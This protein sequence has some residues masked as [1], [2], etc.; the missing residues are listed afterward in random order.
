MFCRDSGATFSIGID[1]HRSAPGSKLLL[2]GIER[3]TYDCAR[4]GTST[5][6]AALDDES[7]RPIGRTQRRHRSAKELKTAIV[8]YIQNHHRDPQPFLWTKTAGQTLASVD[9]FCKRASDSRH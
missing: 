7:V 1:T 4:H 9:R 5:L 2:P 6:F 8:T 3:R